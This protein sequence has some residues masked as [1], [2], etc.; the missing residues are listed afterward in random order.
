MTQQTDDLKPAQKADIAIQIHAVT[1][2]RRLG[3]STLWNRTRSPPVPT[4]APPDLVFQHRGRGDSDG[5]RWIRVPHPVEPA[6]PLLC[7]LV[8]GSGMVKHLSRIQTGSRMTRLTVN[9]KVLLHRRRAGLL[10]GGDLLARFR[11]DHHLRARIRANAAEA[12]PLDL[13]RV[14]R[15][16]DD[17]SDCRR[18][19]GGSGVLQPGGPDDT[20]QH[21]LGGARL[22]GVLVCRLPARVVLDFGQG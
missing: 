11:H 14:R 18:R 12:R 13:H 3:R 10:L 1:R 5:D 15:R 8:R 2:S 6:E 9:L 17:R 22:P 7:D 4:T 20:E 21:P 19:F 16:G